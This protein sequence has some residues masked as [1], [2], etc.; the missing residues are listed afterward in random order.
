MKLT[1]VMSETEMRFRQRIEKLGGKCVYD[2]WL[3]V[4]FNYA[5]I[6][7][8]GHFCTPSAKN[9]NS[10]KGICVICGNIQKSQRAEKAFRQRVE[11]FGGKCIYD[12]W[13]GAGK[14]HAVI[15]INNHRI[16]PMP[17]NIKNSKGLCY[18]C[19]NIEINRIKSM[20]TEQKFR[21]RIQELGGKCIYEKW[22]GT[23]MPHTIICINGHSC[24]PRP[25][26]VLSGDGICVIC[27]YMK[28]TIKTEKRF[29]QR[30]KE[31]G[32]ECIYKK[33]YGINASYAV[34]CK[35]GHNV[36]TCPNGVINR[37][38]G[39]CYICRNI[40]L[41][42]IRTTIAE[43]E[44]RIR[45]EELGGKC[46]YENWFGTKNRYRIICKNNHTISVQP[47]SLQQGNTICGICTGE[48]DIFYVVA[49]QEIVKIGI[50]TNDFRPRLNAH[51][52]AGLTNILFICSN[53]EARLLETEM[54]ELLKKDKYIPVKGIE[55]F[56]INALPFIMTKL[57]EY[58]L[59]N[60][61]QN[62]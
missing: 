8:N 47:N 21:Q 9:V 5:V 37:G 42:K 4:K 29:R 50:T 48:W 51:K 40:R 24:N 17:C 20:K 43:K 32:G 58:D 44:F 3:G 38:N 57:A 61:V 60:E 30:I 49:S 23:G 6:C 19:A 2:K 41:T 45:I 22:Q 15:C 27:G 18:I 39:F 31:L 7:I 34:I 36:M 16:N 35:N 33:W 54:L 12:I 62:V 55:Y 56:S 25:G 28:R 10:G 1:I 46:I 53:L 59:V 26:N 11:Y 52:Y 13:L 14:P